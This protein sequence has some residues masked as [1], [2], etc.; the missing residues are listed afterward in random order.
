MKKIRIF[1]R[2]LMVSGGRATLD[3]L[4]YNKDNTLSHNTSYCMPIV[5][6]CGHDNAQVSIIYYILHTSAVRIFKKYTWS[7]STH[8]IPCFYNVYHFFLLGG[9]PHCDCP[10][11]ICGGSSFLRMC[12]PARG[13]SAGGSRSTP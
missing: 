11:E 4:N 8:C 3:I 5:D 6:D 12:S 2:D 10:P 7:N 9:L 1:M 13:Q